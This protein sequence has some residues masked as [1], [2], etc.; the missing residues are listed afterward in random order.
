MEKYEPIEKE[1][2]GFDVNNV[3]TTSISEI[4]EVPIS[5]KQ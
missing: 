3:I 1:V 2:I 4:A 5:N